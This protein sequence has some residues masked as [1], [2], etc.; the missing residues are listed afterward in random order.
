[1]EVKGC[2]AAN[3]LARLHVT[4]LNAVG[5]LEAEAEAPQAARQQA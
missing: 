5:T 3:R 2:L 1:V 4:G